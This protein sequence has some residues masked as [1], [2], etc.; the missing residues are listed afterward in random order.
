MWLRP[1]SNEHDERGR[2]AVEFLWSGGVR[3]NRNRG[4][5]GCIG[6]RPCAAG[7]P[8]AQGPFAKPPTSALN[9]REGGNREKSKGQSV[10][11][12]RH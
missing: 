7:E 12:V 1:V 3:V 11:P 6:A 10:K 9:E 5:L 8:R 4:S 2:S